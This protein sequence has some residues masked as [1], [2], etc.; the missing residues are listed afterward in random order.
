VIELRRRAYG[1]DERGRAICKQEELAEGLN[2]S[3]I[4]VSRWETGSQ[5]PPPKERARLALAA[6][7]L[8]AGRD[9]QIAFLEGAE[10]NTMIRDVDFVII[11]LLRCLYLAQP[12]LAESDQAELHR[13]GKGIFDLARAVAID[14]ITSRLVTDQQR[15]LANEMIRFMK[16][17]DQ[18]EQ[19]ALGSFFRALGSKMYT[20]GDSR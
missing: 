15:L 2:V 5:D 10:R 13:L 3:S 4:T 7:A 20:E 17:I 16:Q 8:G 1:L 14:G 19:S 9:L 18:S 11:R 6:E 12:W